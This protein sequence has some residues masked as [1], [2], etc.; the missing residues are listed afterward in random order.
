MDEVDAPVFSDYTRTYNECM[1]TLEDRM[2][3]S[4]NETTLKGIAAEMQWMDCLQK[5]GYVAYDQLVSD[6]GTQR[7]TCGDCEGLPQFHASSEFTERMKFQKCTTHVI[8]KPIIDRD[9]TGQ[10]KLKRCG[11]GRH[12]LITVTPQVLHKSSPANMMSSLHHKLMNTCGIE[13]DLFVIPKDGFLAHFGLR[14]RIAVLDFMDHLRFIN[15][16]SDCALAIPREMIRGTIPKKWEKTSLH[17]IYI[18]TFYVYKNCKGF[19]DMINDY[20]TLHVGI[21]L[22]SE[23]IDIQNYIIAVRNKASTTHDVLR[24]DAIGLDDLKSIR[25]SLR[26]ISVGMKHTIKQYM[27]LK[28]V[29]HRPHLVHNHDAGQ[30]VSNKQL[31]K[32]LCDMLVIRSHNV[33][34]KDDYQSAAGKSS[35]NTCEQ[36]NSGIVG[37]V[38]SVQPSHSTGDETGFKT[39]P[40]GDSSLGISES[41]CNLINGK[42]TMGS[43]LMASVFPDRRATDAYFTELYPQELASIIKP[44]VKKKPTKACKAHPIGKFVFET[45]EFYDLHCVTAPG[46]RNVFYRGMCKLKGNACPEHETLDITHDFKIPLMSKMVPKTADSED[47]IKWEKIESFRYLT[48]NN[49]KLFGDNVPTDDLKK[50]WDSHK[51]S[52]YE[53]EKP[54][55]CEQGITYRM[56]QWKN[57]KWSDKNAQHIKDLVMKI[58]AKREWIERWLVN[59]ILGKQIVGEWKKF[60]DKAIATFIANNVEIIVDNGGL[61]FNRQKLSQYGHDKQT[62]PELV[63]KLSK[64]IGIPCQDIYDEMRDYLEEKYNESD[65]SEDEEEYD[66]VIE[67]KAIYALTPFDTNIELNRLL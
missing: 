45:L 18:F 25:P 65:F 43:P 17:F 55:I 11:G 38:T 7:F 29:H 49:I 66:E 2:D 41:I 1:K 32:R 35:Q 67:Q 16:L 15:Q 4:T 46:M 60:K 56:P 59:K 44:F 8:M 54:G 30:G 23:L 12:Q 26:S 19:V 53:H 21:E 6:H 5:D 24:T 20:V 64:Q 51:L 14:F 61:I 63:Q 47:D 34:M 36:T 10:E 39:K 58:P 27:M 9:E 48:E 62:I 13:E 31:T 37:N 33:C 28:H 52:L 50:F 42:M 57:V 3:T 22:P 40:S